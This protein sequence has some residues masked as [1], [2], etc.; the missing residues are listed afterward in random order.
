MIKKKKVAPKPV[1]KKVPEPVK[2][3]QIVA[4]PSVVTGPTCTECGKPAAEGQAE[5]CKEH[6]RRG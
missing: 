1:T 2:V 3:K 5:V 4:I 6:I